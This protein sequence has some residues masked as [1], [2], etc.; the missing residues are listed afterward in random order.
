MPAV[1]EL[2]RVVCDPALAGLDFGPGHPMAPLRLTLT[3][4]LA[5]ELGLLD[6][7]GVRVVGAPLPSDDRDLLAVHDRELVDAVRAVSADPG[8]ATGAFGLGTPDVP[9]FAGMHDAARRV[10][11]ASADAARAV[12]RGEALHAVNAAGGLHHAMRRR[13]SG[14]CVYNDAAAAIAALLA[15][16]CRRVAYVDLDAHHGDGVEEA[17]RDDPRVLTVSVHES[18]ETLFPGTGHDGDAAGPLA[19]GTALSVTLAAGSGDVPWLAAV[20]GALEHVASFGPEVLVS[21]HGADSHRDDPLAHLAVSLDA[22]RSAAAAVHDQAHEVAQG[23]WLALGGGGYAVVD[24]VPRAWAHLIGIAAHAAVPVDAAVPTGWRE[25]V[26]ATTGLDT[27]S[28]MG[29][30]P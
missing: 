29:D 1:S 12:W 3:M 7:P 28:S 4:E 27:P 30:A 5:E 9:A 8:L 15:D 13:A 14:F 26:A 22:Q 2:V 11:G 16:G 17:F 18:P 20:G 6:G 25:R 21:Q 23:R 19:P 10:V 24:V